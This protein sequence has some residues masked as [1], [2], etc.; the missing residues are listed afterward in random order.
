MTC[1]ELKKLRKLV[2][3]EVERRKKIK[4]LLKNE[5]VEEYLELAKIK[6]LNLDENNMRQIVSKILDSYT[7][8]K[9]NGIYV[10]TG[11]YRIGCHAVYQDYSYYRNYISI[12]SEYAE[13]RIYT[14]IE[15]NKTYTATTDENDML[16]RPLMEDFEKDRIILNPHN[17]NE[18]D[19]GF[20]EVRYD[21][22]QASI[23]DGQAKAKKLILDKYPRL[24]Y[25]RNR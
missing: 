15:S 18:K 5:L 1:Y 13:Y 23:E 6:P 10:C 24:E 19:N 8:K 11:A 20:K 9:T 4:E 12:D 7:I 16:K 2:I 21:F 25:G 17:K 3:E 22:F 14:D